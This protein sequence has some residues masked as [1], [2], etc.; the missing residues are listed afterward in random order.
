MKNHWLLWVLT[1][2]AGAAVVASLPLNLPDRVAAGLGVGLAGLSGA[3]VLW[4]RWR[5]LKKKGA[6]SLQAGLAAVGV[7]LLVR[8][9]VLIAGMWLTKGSLAFVVGFFALYFVLQVVEVRF[10]VSADPG[11]RPLSAS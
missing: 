8:L 11:G 6:E 10:L 2:L 4:V 1:V 5:A 7:S 9:L 3:V